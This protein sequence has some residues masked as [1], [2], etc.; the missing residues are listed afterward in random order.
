MWL[1]HR[2][3]AAIP[4][5][6]EGAVTLPE[7]EAIAESSKPEM[8]SNDKGANTQPD[9]SRSF[10]LR[11]LAD[12]TRVFIPGSKR[13][14][15]SASP[16]ELA[17]A[18]RDLETTLK[19][20]WSR[21]LPEAEMTR[22]AQALRQLAATGDREIQLK[23]AALL[24]ADRI[25]SNNEGEA[26]EWAFRAAEA[27]SAEAAM[28]VAQAFELGRGIEPDP[29]LAREWYKYA[30]VQGQADA[31]AELGMMNALGLG[32]EI[33]YDQALTD[34][35]TAF[36]AGSAIGARRIGIALIEGWGAKPDPQTARAWLERAGE[37][38]DADAYLTLWRLSRN[39]TFGERDPEQEA[40]Y[41]FA[42]AEGGNPTAMASTTRL[43][44]RTGAEEAQTSVDA[45]VGSARE[46][47]V[48]ALIT[49]ARITLR[50]DPW[51]HTADAE[52]L[53]WK[54][55]ELGSQTAL[56]ELAYL[57]AH[58][59]IFL[60]KNPRRPID[61]LRQLEELNYDN[62]VSLMI[63]AIEGG[64]A[65]MLAIDK[66]DGLSDAESYLQIAARKERWST[67]PEA[68]LRS[69]DS[70]E[71]QMLDR[72]PRPVATPVP[73]Y[74]PALITEGLS[75]TVRL[76]MVVDT[77]GSVD[78]VNVVRSFHPTFSEAAVEAIE[79]WRFEPAQKNGVSVR[80]RV[81]IDIPFEIRK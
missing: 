34:F 36:E 53:Y 5:G 15:G 7:P 20:L 24:A 70:P 19:L 47:A 28:L 18:E 14:L 4:G 59:P 72:R 45:L 76:T 79:K 69:S 62:R 64:M 1:S 51:K 23:L 67:P 35:E 17:A 71:L 33:D 74:P 27:G 43:L 31:W 73:V 39:E 22:H 2:D 29:M 48:E 8:A 32:A 55:Y 13:I 66:Y 25:P 42:A 58:A 21:R 80:S 50:E 49:L 6:S 56:Y 9:E 77:D 11:Q 44:M 60:L 52:S 3:E 75:G 30:A 37:M 78:S 16:D 63:E 81:Y 46:G 26:L 41:L 68:A 61:L 12:L 38:G 57:N 40:A 54:A 10:R 65:E